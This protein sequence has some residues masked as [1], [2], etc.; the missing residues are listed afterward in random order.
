MVGDVK[1]PY[2]DCPVGVPQGSTLGPILFSLYINNFFDVCKGINAQLYADDAVIFTP[3]K[4]MTEA[5]Q[6]L[7]TAMAHVQDWLAD[8]CLSL[9]VKKS[10]CMIFDKRPP[11]T[12]HSGVFLGGEELALVS[13]FRY[14]GVILDSTL[15]FRKH[16]KKVSNSVKY[17]LANFRQIRNSLTSSAALLFLHCMVFSH[18][19]YCLTSWSLACTTALKPIESLY[20]KAL[21]TLDKK[22]ISFHIC[23]ILKKYNFFSFH[24]F[25]T[26]RFA[27]FIYKSLNGLAP[28]PLN[29]FI[30]KK[31]LGGMSTRA[32]VR[33]DC[34]IPHRR[35][36]YGRNVLSVVG[37]D[38]WNSLPSTIRECPT[39]SSF[40]GNLKH[41]LRS[42]QNCDH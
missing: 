36:T 15:S 33:G 31:A 26:F 11:N 8:S 32:C 38:I 16:I 40:K 29:E 13:E 41:W 1:S 37:G 20:K 24:N 21:K 14:L 22:P 39:F 27:C 5:S 18:I 42:H 3:A 17:N 30:K 2:L 35:T 19:D 25:K 7:T 28:P 12:D 6:I 10:V 4:N 23:K 9:N 34:D